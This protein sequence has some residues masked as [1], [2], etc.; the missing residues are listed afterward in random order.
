MNI[1]K[2]FLPAFIAST[3]LC[4]CGPDLSTDKGKYSYS[5]GNQIGTG[6]TRDGIEPDIKAFMLGFKEGLSGNH[7]SLD[8]REMIDGLKAM[9]EEL[10]QKKE[11]KEK[12]TSR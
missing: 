6:M 4:S 12:P 11:E 10:K 8:D 9:T 7:S 3:L 5:L 1:I 2:T